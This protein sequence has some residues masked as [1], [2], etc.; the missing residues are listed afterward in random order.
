M[1]RKLYLLPVLAIF[2][3]PAIANAQF[4]AGN[5]ELT[6]SGSGSNDQDFRTFDMAANAS[7]GYF[8][9][10]AAEI[11]VRQGLVYADG[12]SDWSAQTL[13][14]FDWHFDLDR[15]QPFIGVN[16]G[17]SYG[18][19]GNQDAWLGGPEVGVKYFVNSTTFIQVTGAYEFNLQEGLDDGA[20]LYS[21]GVGFKW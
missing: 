16:G 13:A 14:A 15:W 12:G 2:A 18:S 19:S 4:Q 20:F 8:L 10:N 7:L 21:L 5:W 11:S 17:Y 3:I 9:T 1:L 6:L